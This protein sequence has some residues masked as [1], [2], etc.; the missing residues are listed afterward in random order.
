[1]DVLLPFIPISFIVSVAA[2][3]ILRPMTTRIGALFETIAHERAPA[4][5]PE[6]DPRVVALL[7]HMSRRLDLIEERID[8]TERLVAARP[9]ADGTRQPRMPSQNTSY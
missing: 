6:G 8:F 9:G 3:L 7:E 4:R 5:A 1:M 2:V